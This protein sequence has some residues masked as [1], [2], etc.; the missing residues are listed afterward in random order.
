LE[1][2]KIVATGKTGFRMPALNLHGTLEH[3]TFTITNGAPVKVSGQGKLPFERGKAK[4]SVDV[5]LHP[6]GNFSGKGT[7]SYKLKD[8]VMVAGTVELDEKQKLHVTG[9]L[10]ISRYEL[11]KEYGDKRDLFTLDVPIPVPALSIG[12]A[13]GL[14]FHIRGGVGVGYSFGPGVIE[15]LKFSAGFDPL[16]SDPDLKLTVTG[17]VKV[18]ASATLTAS[19]SG[20]LAVQVSVVVGSAGAEGGLQLTGELKLTAGAFADLKASYE[21]K[22]LT[23]K[24]VAGIDTQL[25]LGLTLTAFARAWAGAFGI[26]GEL[27]KDWTL[28]KRNIDTHL[29]FYLSAPFEYADDTGIKLPAL[30]DVTLKKPEVTSEN[31]KRILSEI[32][33]GAKETPTQ[34]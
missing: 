23:A 24:V 10:E 11:F 17:K 29:G 32:F 34:K 3:L 27:R 28:A 2:D 4:G 30:Q 8:N 1:E 33:S 13:A 22:K 5:T 31:L 18:P 9:E 21:K 12:T 19:I 16:E 6:S 15:P 20:S 7:L 14:V 25:L 26:T